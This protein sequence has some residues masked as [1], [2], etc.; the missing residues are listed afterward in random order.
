MRSSFIPKSKMPTKNYRDFCLG[1]LLEGRG[2]ISVIFGWH[3]GRND[4]LIYSEFNWP[5]KSYNKSK[6]NSKY[7]FLLKVYIP[8]S[9]LHTIFVLEVGKKLDKFCMAYLGT[10]LPL[11]AYIFWHLGFYWWLV[12]LWCI[13][14]DLR[15]VKIIRWELQL[16]SRNSRNN[17]KNWIRIK[18]LT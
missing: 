5:L 10:L 12:F 1:S 9:H 17:Y 15:L 18:F 14:S 16:N 13:S 11:L 2:E 8:W 7:I 3:F 4:D 6:K